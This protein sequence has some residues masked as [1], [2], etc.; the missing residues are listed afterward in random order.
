MRKNLKIGVSA[1]ICDRGFVCACL[2]GK[3]IKH[4]FVKK[5]CYI[6]QKI[7][8]LHRERERGRER[9]I[10]SIINISLS[11]K[12]F[13]HPVSGADEK[14]F[15]SLTMIAHPSPT[16]SDHPCAS[17]DEWRLGSRQHNGC[18]ASY[19]L[20]QCPRRMRTR[21]FCLCRWC[22]QWKRRRY[23]LIPHPAG[24]IFVIC[25]NNCHIYT[26]FSIFFPSLW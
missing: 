25:T 6:P 15:G 14:C 24:D 22:V 4:E 2:F 7:P 20:P 9:A 3:Y 19:P 13:M 11:F 10:W 8:N 23:S 1:I 26:D 5:K 18:L 12:P 17:G 21:C 16:S